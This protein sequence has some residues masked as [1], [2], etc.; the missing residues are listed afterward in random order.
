MGHNWIDTKSSATINLE[1]KISNNGNDSN[2]INLKEKSCSD[3]HR[4]RFSF[5]YFYQFVRIGIHGVGVIAV[6]HAVELADHGHVSEPVDEI[7]IVAMAS[8]VL[9]NE[10]ALFQFEAPVV[11]IARARDPACTA[12]VRTLIVVQQRLLQR[13]AVEIDVLF[14]VAAVGGAGL[15][16]IIPGPEFLPE[17]G[18]QRRVVRHGDA[19]KPTTL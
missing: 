9:V 15:A 10:T 3:C 17:S 5:F 7:I 11:V 1:S 4:T 8:R 12:S 16:V 18:H 2:A 6:D 13:D 19:R 14:N